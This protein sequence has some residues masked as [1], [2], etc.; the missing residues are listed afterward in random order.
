[1][2]TPNDEAYPQTGRAGSPRPNLFLIG[3]MKSGTSSM[4][5][6]LGMHPEIHMSAEKEPSY[7]VAPE[8]LRVLWPRMYRERYWADQPRYLELF[9]D[10][11]NARWIGESS[12]NYA[13]LPAAPGV[14]ERI[15][16]F[17]PD[18]RIL[19]L[20]REPASRALSHYWHA[21][22]RDFEQ[23]SPERA[24][25]P[26]SHYF[27]VS[28]Y[29]MQLAPYLERFSAAAVRAVTL[30]AFRA[31]PGETYAGILEWL[32]VEAATVPEGLD[33]RHHESPRT[34]WQTRRGALARTWRR[35]RVPASVRR[36]C[37]DALRYYAWRLA[38]KPVT[39]DAAAERRLIARIRAQ[40][41][42]RVEALETLLGR[43]FPEWA[44]SE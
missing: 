14:A 15:H 8:D 42:S 12:T 28:D 10:A 30:E 25:V 2:T 44:E 29:A 43:R 20:M 32:G 38:V 19:Y 9:R 3:A 16:A 11:G 26:G 22:D 6:H 5:R 37:P 7:F 34:L 40:M 41:A 4:H 18:A 39:R 21:V 33:E 24:L 23:A 13:K 35:I 17:A 36:R 1:M 31:R 27:D